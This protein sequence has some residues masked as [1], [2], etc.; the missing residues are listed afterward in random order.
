MCERDS[1]A[2]KR[3]SGERRATGAPGTWWNSCASAAYGGAQGCRGHLQDMEETNT[4]AGGFLREGC[5]PMG[6]LSWTRL[7]AVICGLMERGD[8]AGVGFLK[9]G[10]VTLWGTHSG[11][12]CSWRTSPPEEVCMLQQ[13]MK[14]CCPWGGLRLQKPME[15][16]LSW[17]GP[18]GGAEEGLEKFSV[19][20]YPLDYLNC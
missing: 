10:P 16:C 4:R 6:N 5:E 19:W 14:D 1:F 18:T 9:L 7:L 2:D 13:L 12:G 8:H 20:K 11:A 17:E 3:V 15:A